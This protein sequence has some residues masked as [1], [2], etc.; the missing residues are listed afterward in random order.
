MN[1]EENKICD[2]NE[3]RFN[4]T[5]N[6]NN[7]NNIVVPLNGED[8]KLVSVLW[9]SLDYE[10]SDGMFIKLLNLFGCKYTLPYTVLKINVSLLWS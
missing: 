1:M 3:L 5:N 7:N 9:L 4:Y 10:K 2:L 6:N 8:D